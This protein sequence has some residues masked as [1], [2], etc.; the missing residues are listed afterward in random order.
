MLG[1]RH[2]VARRADAVGDAFQDGGEVADRDAL[3]Q[4][5]LQHALDAGD[6]DQRRHQ[7]LEQFGLFLRQL[8]EQ[9]L[10]LAI[11]QQLRHVVLQQFGQMRGQHGGGV[12]HGVALERGLFL[13]P[14]VDPGGRQAEGRLG[15]VGAR[16]FHLA[17]AR[18]HD[19]VLAGP[20]LAA[21]GLDL[22][23]LDDV[24]VCVELHVVEDAHGRHHETHLGGERVAQR[25]DLLGQPVGAVGRIDQRQQR[26]AEL[27]LEVVH[28]ERGGNRLV[29]G[30]ALGGGVRVARLFGGGDFGALVDDVGEG[31]GAAAEREER[32]HRDS[33]Q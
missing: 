8:L 7:V 32:Q 14:G 17:A 30:L 16:Q 26:I 28:F 22:L 25:L 15:G 13:G 1:Q 19:H 5:D 18:V 9:L 21:A 33:R 6:C 27:D 2:G 4:Q 31:A 11:G 23:D 24:A 20:D 12:H 29:L 3:G 10:H